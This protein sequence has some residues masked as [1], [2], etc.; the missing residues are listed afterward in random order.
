VLGL[1]FKGNK[2]KADKNIKI[3]FKA[4]PF[5][6]FT[7]GSKRILQGGPAPY[8]MARTVFLAI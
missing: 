4:R 6:G 7:A 2:T 8:L 3:D 1:C 5:M